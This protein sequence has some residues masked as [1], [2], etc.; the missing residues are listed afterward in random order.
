MNGAR[1]WQARQQFSLCQSV[2]RSSQSV[3][4]LLRGVNTLYE[5]VHR[6]SI[7]KH[8]GGEA[9][10]ICKHFDNFPRGLTKTM[11]SKPDDDHE[12]GYL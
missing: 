11:P 10:L 5:S 1:L 9:V 2:G 6:F 7:P 12:Q 4:L 8:L 3:Q